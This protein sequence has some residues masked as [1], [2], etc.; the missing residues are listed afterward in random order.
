MFARD[1][2]DDRLLDDLLRKRPPAQTHAI[3]VEWER[4]N[5]SDASR[6]RTLSMKDGCMT[7]LPP[8]AGPFARW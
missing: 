1:H 4:S 8:T 3:T 6:W 2:R 5:A 7:Q